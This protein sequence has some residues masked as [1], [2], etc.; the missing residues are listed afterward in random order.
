[1]QELNCF[2]L[3]C[4]QCGNARFA[5][6]QSIYCALENRSVVLHRSCP[7]ADERQT[8]RDFEGWTDSSGPF[9]S[10]SSKLRSGLVPH[11]L[12]EQ[13]QL[14]TFTVALSGAG[15]NFPVVCFYLKQIMGV[16]FQQ[17]SP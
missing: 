2:P 12:V 10:R 9:Y 3:A 16:N 6:K 13:K 14:K 8:R 15:G 11:S 7:K 17:C 5:L 1:M 4:N